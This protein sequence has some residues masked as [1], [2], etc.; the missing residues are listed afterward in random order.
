MFGLIDA[1]MIVVVVVERMEVTVKSRYF[2]QEES[3]GER[4]KEEVEVN[5]VGGF[6]I[7]VAQREKQVIA[8]SRPQPAS[9]ARF[10]IGEN[11]RKIVDWV[12]IQKWETQESRS[13]HNKTSSYMN[14]ANGGFSPCHSPDRAESF[15]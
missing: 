9:L 13:N 12:E 5:W 6:F 2:Y 7:R 4:R 14:L 11:R 3:V 1:K 8:R 10:G 15:F